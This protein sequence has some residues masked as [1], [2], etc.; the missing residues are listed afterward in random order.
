LESDRKVKVQCY[1]ADE[2]PFAPLVAHPDEPGAFCFPPLASLITGAARLMLGL[3]EHEVTRLGGTYAM[4]DT[5][6]MAIVATEQGGMI[7][8]PGGEDGKINALTCKQVEA[9][10]NKFAALNPYDR[11]D[12]PG[13]IL[14]IEDDN[15]DPQTGEPRQIYC[16]AISAKRYALFL[17][18]RNGE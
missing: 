16:F 12:V 6:S 11:N 2:E 15:R 14:K 9:I 10:S 13:S 8:C 7:P 4:E 17:L 3:L 1:G 18:S 5:D